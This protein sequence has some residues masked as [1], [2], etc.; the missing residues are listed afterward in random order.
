MV[1]QP[2]FFPSKTIEAPF[3]PYY[4]QTSNALQ[5]RPKFSAYSSPRKINRTPSQNGE[6]IPSS[7]DAPRSR[8]SS[9]M[10]THTSKTL[11]NQYIAKD[12]LTAGRQA[13][14]YLNN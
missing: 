9:P 14:I 4:N 12:P 3:D 8:Y 7:V 2:S 10:S 1:S 13:V 11:N 6:F 5:N